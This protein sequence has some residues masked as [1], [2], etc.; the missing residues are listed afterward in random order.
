[1]TSFYSAEEYVMV[2]EGAFIPNAKK[3][4]TRSAT[5][6]DNSS[7]IKAVVIQGY[8][9][10]T[11]RNHRERL[12]RAIACSKSIVSVTIA[13]F[14]CDVAYEF[15]EIIQ[16][17]KNIEEL[18]FHEISS[19]RNTFIWSRICES[20]SAMKNLKEI[21]FAHCHLFSDI[22]LFLRNINVKR[23]VLHVK[24]KNAAKI[25]HDDLLML[26]QESPRMRFLGFY[27][28]GIPLH[29]ESTDLKTILD[30]RKD[31]DTTLRDRITIIMLLAREF[32]DSSFLSHLP[33][34]LLV[35]LF[36]NVGFRT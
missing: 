35:M 4:Y 14:N 1:M 33:L 29:E 7:K 18:H 24:W 3:H 5:I 8:D 34:N 11:F 36:Y 16:S 22:F 26:V 10:N 27:D 9:E 32:D 28:R 25:L 31:W 2:L 23:L 15:L 30:Q 6:I 21:C 12:A 19:F 17:N 20:L 13:C